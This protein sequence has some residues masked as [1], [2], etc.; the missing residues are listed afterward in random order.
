[1]KEK[2]EIVSG[3]YEVFSSGT[4]IGISDESITFHL[5]KE[6]VTLKYIVKFIRDV[7]QRDSHVKFV[8]LGDTELE[9]LFVNFSDSLGTG[10]TE[11]L[12][13]GVIGNRKLFFNY[14]VY[15]IQG[16]SNTLHYTFYL[17]K[18]VNHDTK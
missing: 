4:V 17:A 18:E 11:L 2:V 5:T 14:R 3:K 15:A 7:T 12:E 8:T 10:N 1:M 9:M 16:L 6:N 13:I